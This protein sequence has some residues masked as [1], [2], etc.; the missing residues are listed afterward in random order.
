MALSCLCGS[1][2]KQG[3]ISVKFWGWMSRDRAGK[4]QR[5]DGT[6][7]T[8]QYVHILE[9]VFYPSAHERYPDGP[10]LF[11]Q[12]NYAVYNSMDV[13][14]WLSERTEIEE[15]ALPPV[16]PY[17]NVIE[18]AWARLKGRT[19]E[20]IAG[21]QLRNRD[22]LWDHV[23][24]AWEE[25]AQDLEYFWRLVDSMPRRAEAVREAEGYWTKY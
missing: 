12:D 13:Q 10:L 4:L 11:L 2:S 8:H 16:L 3:C 6:L 9:H 24:D 17:L 5:I 14:R 22:E 19:R 18:N 1:N 25:I 15:I 23:L 20:L 7:R 21:R